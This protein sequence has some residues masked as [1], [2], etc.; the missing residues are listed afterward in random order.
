MNGFDIKTNHSGE[1]VGEFDF[2]VTLFYTSNKLN[3]QNCAKHIEQIPLKIIGF[4]FFGEEKNIPVLLLDKTDGLLKT[5]RF[6]ENIGMVDQWGE[7]WKPHI[8]VSYNFNGEK[9]IPVL[10]KGDIYGNFLV[11]EDQSED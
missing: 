5:R 1:E 8:S 6:F 10:P 9:K 4:E 7:D 11:I 3:V 2:H